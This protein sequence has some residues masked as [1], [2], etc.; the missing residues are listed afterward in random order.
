MHKKDSPVASSLRAHYLKMEIKN[1][2]RSWSPVHRNGWLIKFSVY[3]DS[4]ILLLF[5]SRYT[6][7]TII[8]YFSEEDDACNFINYIVSHDAKEYLDHQ[9][10]E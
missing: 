10:S 4:N 1:N 7:Q 2:S 8:R 9:D 5:V 3:K 6:G